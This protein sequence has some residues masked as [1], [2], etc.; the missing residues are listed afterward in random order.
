MSIKINFA[1]GEAASKALEQT[2]SKDY[3]AQDTIS[4]LL[5]N[6]EKEI[7]AKRKQ[8]VLA[9]EEELEL[10]TA[11]AMYQLND[12][13]DNW[14]EDT[15]LSPIFHEQRVLLADTQRKRVEFSEAYDHQMRNY[16]NQLSQ[17]EDD[18]LRE[19]RQLEEAESEENTNGNNY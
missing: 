14:Q 18:Y 4:K 11:R 6:E 7:L 8:Q 1:V 17:R 10:E 3:I 5:I 16:R 2:F 15:L 12:S 19:L 13:F 9:Q